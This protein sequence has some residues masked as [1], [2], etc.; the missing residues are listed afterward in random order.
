VPKQAR[1][2]C[3]WIFLKISMLMDE[4]KAHEVVI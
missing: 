1:F 2:A 4:I 3:V